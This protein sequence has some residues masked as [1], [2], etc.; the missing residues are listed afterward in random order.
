LFT[1]VPRFKECPGG[2]R[3]AKRAPAL[4]QVEQE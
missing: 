3:A 2:Y 1:M 4:F